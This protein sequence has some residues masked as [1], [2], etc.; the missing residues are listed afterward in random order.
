MHPVFFKL[1][2]WSDPQ[3]WDVRPIFRDAAWG[4]SRRGRVRRRTLPPLPP[5]A[6]WTGFYSH[7]EG[8]SPCNK[9]TTRCTRQRLGSP[10]QGV[11]TTNQ[12]GVGPLTRD[13]NKRRSPSPWRLRR[14]SRPLLRTSEWIANGAALANH[15]PR[16]KGMWRGDRMGHRN[17]PSLTRCV[18]QLPKP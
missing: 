15:Q 5:D 8:T 12:N 13:A 3:E 16:Q 18:R 14:S 2:L 7:G 1:T 6:K 9:R 17:H 10:T 11:A 4:S